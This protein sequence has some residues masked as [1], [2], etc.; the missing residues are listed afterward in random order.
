MV[1][2]YKEILEHAAVIWA[3]IALIPGVDFIDIPVILLFSSLLGLSYVQFAIIYY[4]LALFV[5]I[6]LAP[7]KLQKIYEKIKRFLN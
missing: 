6:L 7:R 2:D 5:L 4:T 1:K 3:T